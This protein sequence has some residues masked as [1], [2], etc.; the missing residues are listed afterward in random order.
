MNTNRFFFPYFPSALS[1]P[2]HRS[3]A[4][5]AYTLCHFFL[6]FFFLLRTRNY[7]PSAY[8]GALMPM[9]WLPLFACPSFK[10]LTLCSGPKAPQMSRHQQVWALKQWDRN[11]HIEALQA[12]VGYRGENP[13]SFPRRPR[14]RVLPVTQKPP[15]FSSLLQKCFFQ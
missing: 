10:V 1:A 6:F 14:F 9:C 3:V 2:R 4:S 5:P 12:S 11:A 15:F 8:P 7:P 13:R